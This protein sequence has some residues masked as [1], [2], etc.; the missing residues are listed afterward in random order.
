MKKKSGY[1]GRN[2]LPTD[3]CNVEAQL[4][5]FYVDVLL[6]NVDYQIP[7]A[8]L[9]TGER[10]RESGSAHV[11]AHLNVVPASGLFPRES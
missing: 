4:R 10:E 7:P 5:V 9:V 6:S 11:L 3:A 2:S 1:I 8:V